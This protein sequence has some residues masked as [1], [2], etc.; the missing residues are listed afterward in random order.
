MA[1]IGGLACRRFGVVRRA[2][3]GEDVRYGEGGLFGFTFEGCP[4]V[5]VLA[6]I[7]VT[8]KITCIPC[9]QV[10]IQRVC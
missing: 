3:F 8:W 1:V 4:W 10:A 5:I 2:W 7:R 6:L 9:G